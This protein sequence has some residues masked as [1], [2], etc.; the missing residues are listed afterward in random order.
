M[1]FLSGRQ[2]NLIFFD[3][4]YKQAKYADLLKHFENLKEHLSSK[5]QLISR[6]IF[7]LVFATTY[8]Q[9]N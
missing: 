8:A 2:S 1:D 9:V 5:Q 4:L 3:L 7:V 6:S